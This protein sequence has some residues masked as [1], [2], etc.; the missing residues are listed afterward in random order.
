MNEEEKRTGAERTKPRFDLGESVA[1]LT[2]VSLVYHGIKQETEAVRNCSFEVKKGEFTALVGPSGCG[3]T[4]VLSML[5]GI[6]KPSSGSV[7]VSGKPPDPRDNL[8]GYML[9]RDHLLDWRTIEDNVILGLEVKGL[10]SD[11]T[12]TYA[13]ELLDKC[14]LSAFARHYP[15]QLS[16]GMRQKAALVRTL[17][18]S[19]ELLLLD[20]P[21]SA[22]DYQ[23]R[24][25]LSGEVHSIIKR[26]GYTAVLVTHD[27]SE[28]IAMSD[29]IIVFS[30]RPAHVRREIAV[31]LDGGPME[32]RANREFNNY[33]DMVWSELEG[34]KGDAH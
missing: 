17:A 23:T 27:I 14:A 24:L 29:R 19:P 10:L 31:E 33:F 9:Q 20:E 11:E 7:L 15:R 21:F 26:G 6:V 13:L 16:G 30:S 8:T 32:R 34:G 1:K 4:S 18:F 5:A 22:L 3:K 2:N 28:A 12:R 25:L